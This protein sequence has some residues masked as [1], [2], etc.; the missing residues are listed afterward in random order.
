[1]TRSPLATFALAL[2][3]AG[4]ITLGTALQ[5]AHADDRSAA[6]QF[7]LDGAGILGSVS[8][9]G[10]RTGSS[11][12]F[13]ADLGTNGRTCGTCHVA[14]DA[15]TFTPAHARSLSSHDPLFM[16]NDGSD[17]PPTTP[18]QGPNSALSSEVVRYG[19]IRVQIGILPTANYA[20]TS[21]TNPKGCAIPPGSPGVNG[22][23][24]LFRRP[25]PST[26]LIFDS[27]VM[28]DGRE[29][30]QP[31]TTQANF[32]GIDP[33]LFDLADQANSAT[34]GHAQGASIDGTPAQSDIVEFETSL[35]TAQRLLFQPRQRLLASLSAHG[36]NGGADYLADT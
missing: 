26:N 14:R 23:L 12:G 7:S 8:T 1:M 31:L 21:A 27:A 4:S 36:A 18:S 6:A 33:L 22:Q 34:M 5:P 29:T 30:L 24:F 17:C 19:L 15:W 13:F 20:L 2:I 35:Y 11:N 9:D 16:P 10:F 32:H 28:W 25:L 3:G